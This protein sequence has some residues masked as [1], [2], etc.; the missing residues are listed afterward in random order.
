MYQNGSY[1]LCPRPKYRNRVHSRR[2]RP[3]ARCNVLYRVKTVGEESQ[4]WRNYPDFCP[5]SRWQATMSTLLDEPPIVWT[6][7]SNSK[8][9]TGP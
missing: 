5:R 9:G 6:W 8:S 2:T 4:G 3:R 7:R 1:R